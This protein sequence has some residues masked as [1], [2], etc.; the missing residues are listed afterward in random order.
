MSGPKRSLDVSVFK[1]IDCKLAF[2]NHTFRDRLDIKEHLV[3]HTHF[4]NG[5]RGESGDFFES[6]VAGQEA[7]YTPFLQFCHESYILLSLISE[8]DFNHFT[9]LFEKTWAANKIGD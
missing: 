6:T 2:K 8:E 4:A 1:I 7:D 5:E 3:K 9:H